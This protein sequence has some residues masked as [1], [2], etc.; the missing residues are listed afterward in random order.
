[1]GHYL[2]LAF[3]AFSSGVT[4]WFIWFMINYILI[5]YIYLSI[6][7]LW[8]AYECF[9]HTTKGTRKI[10]IVETKIVHMWNKYTWKNLNNWM[11][12]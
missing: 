4:N 1:M 3:I 5:N 6:I 12:K 9:C 7:N 8:D 10:Y 11:D 2:D